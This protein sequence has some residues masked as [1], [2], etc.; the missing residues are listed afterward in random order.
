MA[1][2]AF[3]YFID[4]Q[5]AMK[6]VFRVLKKGK[7]AFFIVGNNRT[8]AGEELIDIP[9]DDFIVLIGQQVGFTF[10]QKMNLDVQK[11]YMIYSKNA[12]NTESVLRTFHK[13]SIIYYRIISNVSFKGN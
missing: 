4:M 12:I 5:L 9:T 6:Q 10:E 11:S 7:Y 8:T 13:N 2:L 3:K 1:A